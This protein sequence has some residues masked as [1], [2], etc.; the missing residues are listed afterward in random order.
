MLDNIT[1]SGRVGCES[2]GICYFSFAWR[3]LLV[4]G[5]RYPG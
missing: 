5:G 4:I 2:F 1:I 3:D